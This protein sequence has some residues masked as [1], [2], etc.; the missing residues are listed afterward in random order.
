MS[1]S[2]ETPY[3]AQNCHLLTLP[4]ELLNY[5]YEMALTYEEAINLVLQTQ[6]KFILRV[7]IALPS[8]FRVSQEV[9]SE[10]LKVFFA[11]NTFEA[12]IHNR[13]HLE[14]YMKCIP[15]IGENL[16]RI[17]RFDFVLYF[18]TPMVKRLVIKAP[19]GTLASFIVSTQHGLYVSP[20]LDMVH[21]NWWCWESDFELA[22]LVKKAGDTGF[23]P[24]DYVKFVEMLY[25]C[26]EYRLS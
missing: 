20:G 10:A 8:L 26:D 1:N 22:A 11:K 9:R 24:E 23:G 21:S 6:P 5:I 13:G 2:T 14:G 17:P 7:G 3:S 19:R 25:R 16:Y 4:V 15:K 18:S 12:T